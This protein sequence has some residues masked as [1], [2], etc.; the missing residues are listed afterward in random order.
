MNPT[1][2]VSVIIPVLNG[3]GVIGDLL[4]CLC[5]QVNQPQI[6]E[7][8]V[9]DN[10]S[11]DETCSI[12]QNFP[13]KLLKENKPGPGAARNRGLAS[14]RGEVIAYLDADTLPSRKWIGE[15]VK[16]FFDPEITL[17][18]GKTISYKP[19]TPAE[20]FYAR[21]GIHKT[22][23]E[24][25]RA[26]FPF[27]ASRNLAV[28]RT[29]AIAIGGWAEDLLT[30]EDI[31]FC[32][33]I[34]Q[35]VPGKTYFQESAVLFHRDRK[36]ENTLLRQAWTYG[37]GLAKIYRRYPE[38]A[39]WGMRQILQVGK[40][41]AYRS[42]RPTMLKIGNR[43]GIVSYDQVEFAVYLNKWSWYFWR[44]FGHMYSTGKSKQ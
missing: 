17:V 3:A 5:N 9:V 42:I 43:L 15:I 21:F 11:Q 10:G 22:E 25:S 38:N 12:A 24:L 19:E 34:Q 26:R 44:G 16:P 30:A 13:V 2:S 18:G 7:I 32:Y 35:Q 40:V 33:R 27:F 20:R 8:L 37:E 36:D 28:R 23:F 29:A 31:D 1:L 4:T 6:V 39:P 14:A 41:L